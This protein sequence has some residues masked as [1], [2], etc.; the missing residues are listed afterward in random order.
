MEVLETQVPFDET[1]KTFFWSSNEKMDTIEVGD[2]FIIK[3]IKVLNK[4]GKIHQ[5]RKL[6]HKYK[7]KLISKYRMFESK[8][9]D[10]R[11]LS[12]YKNLPQSD[13]DLY[14]FVLENSRSQGQKGQ[15]VPS[16]WHLKIKV[17]A[18]NGT[19]II[20]RFF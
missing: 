2:N 8:N 7:V 4:V 9:K 16:R 19:P 18:I 3:P 13:K 10:P 1:H 14:E 20:H 6:Q 11:T 5:R 15:K 12:Y 17:L